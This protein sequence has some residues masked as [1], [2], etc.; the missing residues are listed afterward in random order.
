MRLEGGIQDH[1]AMRQDVS[2][3]PVVYHG[4]RH[5]TKARMVVL[6]VVPLEEGLA[7]AASVFDGTEAIREAGA[8]FEGSELT[9]RIWIVIED[10]R[11]AVGFDDAQIGQ[12]QSHR[13]GFHGRAAIG[14]DGE[15]AWYD[16]LLQAGVF[17]EPLGQHGAFAVG[18]HPVSRDGT[19]LVYASQSRLFTRRLDQPKANELAGTEGAYAP[20]FSPDGQW[21]AFFTPGKL[22]KISVEGGLQAT[23]R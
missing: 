14:M 1:L 17:D 16:V 8:V 18:D 4:R 19:R 6:V 11:P 2:G 23:C 15:L 20:F 12:Q 21:V 3:L 5:Q 13:F 9:F 10:M 22:K 7:E